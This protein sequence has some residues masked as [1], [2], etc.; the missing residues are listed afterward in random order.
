MILCE[1]CRHN[2]ATIYRTTITN[3]VK[4][5]QRLCAVCAAQYGYNVGFPT[6]PINNILNGLFS[7]QPKRDD[8]PERHCSGCGRSLETI[9]KTGLIGCGTCY[10]DFAKEL[11]PVLR[12][13]QGRLEHTG[14]VPDGVSGEYERNREIGRLKR[15]LEAAVEEEKYELAAMLRD[16]IAE[17][18][19]GPA[20]E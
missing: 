1:E 13:V 11:E 14:A 16:K 6:S 4:K 19:N 3:G 20:G 7:M 18:K 15:E 5:E 17:L 10:R 9:K 8:E 12:R 2:P